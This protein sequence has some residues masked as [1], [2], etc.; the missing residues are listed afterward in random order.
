[1]IGGGV[2]GNGC[3]Q[4][5][6]RFLMC[7]EFIIARLFTEKLEANKSLLVVGVERF[8]SYTGY[9]STFEHAGDRADLTQRNWWGL[10]HCKMIAIDARVFHCYTDQFKKVS[11]ERELNKDFSGFH[12]PHKNASKTAV[13]T[14]NWG[15][16]AFIRVDFCLKSL[17][18]LMAVLV[19][20]R[21]VVYFTFKDDVLAEKLTN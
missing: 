4:E 10:R 8:N 19:A 18:Q 13:A 5:E 12:E 6:I 21:Y 17:L 9:D 16:R 14:G 2:V 3:V 11:L 1:M 20:K 7:P 15:C